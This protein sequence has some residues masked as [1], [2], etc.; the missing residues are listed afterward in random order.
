MGHI[1]NKR[2]LNLIDNCTIYRK[3]TLTFNLSPS[4]TK[5]N[6]LNFNPLEVASRYRDPKK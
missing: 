2:S 6:S 4:R 1:W 3:K 5:L